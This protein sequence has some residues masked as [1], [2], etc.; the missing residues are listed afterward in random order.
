MSIQS[1][2]EQHCKAGSLKLHVPERRSFVVERHVFLG[3]EARSFIDWDGTV[4]VKFDTVSARAGSVLDRF[5][6][7]SYVT[8]GM[9]PH[10]KKSTSLIARVDPVGDGIV[11]FRITDP[12]PAVRIFGSFAAVDVIVLLTW[13]PRQDCDFKAEVTRC[14][15]VWD[16]LFPKHLPIVSEKIESYVSK[17][18]D[19]G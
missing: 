14:R 19:A 7:G 9:D 2:I 5:C 3:G 4:D 6:N 10:N 16:A 15:K 17:H 11:D 13:S 8:V 18:F 1:E 12:N